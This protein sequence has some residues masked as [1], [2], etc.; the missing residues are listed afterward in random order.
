VIH[1]K[2]KAKYSKKGTL[3]SIIP[4][5]EETSTLMVDSKEEDEEKLW[6][7]VEVISYVITAHSQDIW[8]GTVTTLVPLAVTATHMNVS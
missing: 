1:I 5:E 4:Q 6:A 3:H 2:F 8:Q 7:E